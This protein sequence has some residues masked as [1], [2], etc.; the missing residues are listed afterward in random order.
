MLQ[1]EAQ[2][3]YRRAKILHLLT[4]A[5]LLSSGPTQYCFSHAEVCGG[6]YR[7]PASNGYLACVLTRQDHD[8]CQSTT[9]NIVLKDCLVD[10]HFKW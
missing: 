3:A 7:G 6:P 1:A 4:S 10:F 2:E 8:L 9:G 5:P